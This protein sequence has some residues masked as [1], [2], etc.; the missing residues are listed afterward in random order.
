M[1]W[2]YGFYVRVA[3][4]ISH[5]WLNSS[6]SD[7]RW[8][9]VRIDEG[10]HSRHSFFA[11]P[12]QTSLQSTEAHTAESLLF[13]C[14]HHCTNLKETP[15]K[16]SSPKA[17]FSS[18]FHSLAARRIYLLPRHLCLQ[19]GHRFRWPCFGSNFQYATRE[20]YIREIR[21]SVPGCCE[22]WILWVF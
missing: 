21:H 17:S 12:T 4:A 22:I 16:C 5:L 11:Q 14:P 3:R 6:D 1:A 15:W 2:R 19:N 10:S 18:C 20:R 8:T 13:P 9:N 7:M